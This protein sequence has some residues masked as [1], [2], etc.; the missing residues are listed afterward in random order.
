MKQIISLFFFLCIVLQ[1][2]NAQILYFNVEP[3]SAVVDEY[4][5]YFIDLNQDGT[6]D[7]EIRNF[8]PGGNIGK[9]VEF[10]TGFIGSS[11]SGEV[12]KASSYPLALNFNDAIGEV[13]NNS[14][15]ENGMSVLN[16]NGIRGKWRG[17]EDKYLALRLNIDEHYYYGWARL[18]VPTDASY[19][20]IKDFALNQSP[21]E[22]IL[23]GQKIID[24]VEE[25]NDDY[26]LNAFPN[27]FNN[28]ITFS[29]PNNLKI[30]G[31]KL[32]NIYGVEVEAKTEISNNSVILY[33][34]NLI[35]G[36]Y[37]YEL[38]FDKGKISKGK[39]IISE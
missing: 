31:L 4:G 26:S 11:Y 18:D 1:S 9:V 16:D 30:N 32:F 35:S 23:A 19:F 29:I 8:Q 38:M 14:L 24:G 7:F 39:V 5:S 33:K 10:Y 25:I 6:N 17:V 13:P 27:P 34:G 12:L 3:D 28:Y 36:F 37:F 2:A 21:D 22:Q 15:W 20:I